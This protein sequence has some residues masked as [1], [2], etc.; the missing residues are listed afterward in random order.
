MALH[1]PNERLILFSDAVMAITITLL[2]LEIR[3]PADIGA[4]TDPELWAALRTIAPHLLGYLISFAVIGSFWM[5]HHQ[6]F[7]MITGANRGLLP[8]NLL[9]LCAI[10]AIP[11]VTGMLAENSGVLSTQIYAGV[12]T[13]C[14]TTLAGLWLYA[15][16]ARLVDPAIPRAAQW[17]NLVLSGTMILV[18]ALSIPL[19]RLDADLA[20]YSWLL[21]LPLVVLQRSRARA[22]DGHA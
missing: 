5:G 20:K 11:F 13:A 12:M 21:L 4:M 10:S 16:L 2:V 17:R 1:N 14:A 22:A 19:A 18:F 7:T 3:L 6:K 9:F 8:V 15:I